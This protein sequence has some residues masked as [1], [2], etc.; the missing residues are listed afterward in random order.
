MARMVKPTTTPRPPWAEEA[1]RGR[2][3]LCTLSRLSKTARHAMFLRMT[4]PKKCRDNA[5]TAATLMDAG[6][7]LMDRNI[8]RRHPGKSEAEI[9]AMFRAWLHRIGDAVPGDTAGAVRVRNRQA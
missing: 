3:V 2:T 5:Q 8:R 1:P 6:I 9:D 4:N 7:D